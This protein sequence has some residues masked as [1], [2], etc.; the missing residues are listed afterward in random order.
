MITEKAKGGRTRTRAAAGLRAGTQAAAPPDLRLGGRAPVHPGKFLETRFLTPLG[1]SQQAL[2]AELGISRRRVN[3]LIRGHRSITPDTAIRL[4]VFFNTD[5]AFWMGL[6]MAWDM[7]HALR[8]YRR[9]RAT[10][11]RLR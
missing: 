6:Q 3:E 1:I 11:S 8:A 7:H 9:E 2:A 5:A 10:P 4:A